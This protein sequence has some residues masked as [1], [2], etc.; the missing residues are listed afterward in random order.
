MPTPPADAAPPP[1]ATEPVA[2]L[3]GVTKTY[4]ELIALRDVELDLPKGAVG[5]LGPN[6]AGKS[7]LFRLLLGLEIPDSGTVDV[8]GRA[9]PDHTLDVLAR[10]GY[11]PEDDSLFPGLNGIEQVVHAA[12]LSGLSATDARSRAHQ[13]LDLCGL[14][15]ARYRLGASYSLGMRQR[16]RLAMAMAHGPELLILDEPT[17]GLDP[18][19]RQQMLDLVAEIAAAGVAVVLSTHVLPDVE[20]VCDHVVLLSRGQVGYNGTVAGFKSGTGSRWKIRVVGDA[21]NLASA[22]RAAG[23]ECEVEGRSVVVSAPADAA[24]MLWSLCVGAGVGVRAFG[25]LEEDMGSAFVRHLR[26]D[27]PLRRQAGAQRQGAM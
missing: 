17:A 5:L 16:L 21:Q 11:M 23:L 15:D 9:M 24:A 10:V 4:D 18:E 27:D 26:I 8:L 2:A 6:G 1:P 13:A 7:T 22:V 20:A 14:A 19:G 25:P 3:R 12:Q